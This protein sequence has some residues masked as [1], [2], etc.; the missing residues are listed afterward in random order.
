ML[1]MSILAIHFK[2]MELQEF[3]DWQCGLIVVAF[4]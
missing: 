1:M 4:S 2:F 3:M